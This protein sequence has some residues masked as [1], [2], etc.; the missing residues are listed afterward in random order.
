[1]RGLKNI[2]NGD[3]IGSGQGERANMDAVRLPYRRFM[4]ELC[5][6]LLDAV[7]ECENFEFHHK[8]DKSLEYKHWERLVT[9]FGHA[10]Q[11]IAFYDAAK[12]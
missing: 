11:R 10:R 1:M 5:E 7:A 2:M 9:M 4:V 3:I 6:E 8:E 12:K